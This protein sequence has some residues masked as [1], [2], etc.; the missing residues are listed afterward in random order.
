MH[1]RNRLSTPS[2]AGEGAIE[3]T[4]RR[5]EAQVGAVR[6]PLKVPAPPRPPQPRVTGPIAGVARPGRCAR[7]PRDS[8]LCRRAP[9]RRRGRAGCPGGGPSAPSPSP[10]PRRRGPEAAPAAVGSRREAFRCRRPPG[11]WLRTGRGH[12]SP[13]RR[14]RREGGQAPHCKCC[15]PRTRRLGRPPPSRPRAP[16]APSSPGSARRGPCASSGNPPRCRGGRRSSRGPSSSLLASSCARTA[17]TRPPRGGRSP[18][19]AG[20]PVPV[21]SGAGAAAPPPPPP[22]RRREPPPA[23]A[24]PRPRDRRRLS[25]APCT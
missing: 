17:G 10:A 2:R 14:R 4:R 20:R 12:T 23:W 25:S 15:P 13:R 9:G 1:R 3:G 7:A 18:S 16:R 11:G 19:T 22:R 24:R 5:L 6:S 8:S 21:R